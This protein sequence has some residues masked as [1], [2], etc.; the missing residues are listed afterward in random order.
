ML[1]A[2][3]I[4]AGILFVFLLISGYLLATHVLPY[5]ILQP[6]H[7][8]GDQTPGNYG[9]PYEHFKLQPAGSIQLDAFYVPAVGK[10]RANLIMLHGVGSCK[11]VYLNSVAELVKT[12]YN[13]LLWD[14]RAHGKSGGKY[15]TYGA[16][17]KYDVSLAIDWLEA[18]SPDL[19][20]GIYGNS[21]GGA[22][23]IQSLAHDNRLKFGLI[24]STFIDLR[25]VA[26]AY[27]QRM[28]GVPLPFWL[29]DYVLTRAGQIADFD[30]FSVRPVDVASKVT[31]PIM[32]IHGDAD[33]NINVSH[34][35]AL[36]D[37]YASK[38][39]QLYIVNNGDHADLWEKGGEGYR[40]AWF[41][42]LRR[43]L[44]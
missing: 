9:L 24:E 37:A 27:G 39:K 32:H 15:L 4:I 35:H 25:T 11:E 20:T 7:K 31:Q 18:K 1:K 28:G 44:E 10:A 16:A 23:A 21:M 2:I 6:G 40:E 34:A 19:S 13:V 12:G 8:T 41:G 30:P 38:D 3:L 14:Q 33:A 5:A 26:N 17:E 29:S 22:V 42:F 43:M 36:F